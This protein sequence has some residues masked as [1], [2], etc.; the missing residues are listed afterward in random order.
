[1][2]YQSPVINH[3]HNKVNVSITVSLNNQRY[4]IPAKKT[5]VVDFDMASVAND[6]ERSE[7][8]SLVKN[9]YI[10]VDV[11]VL[12]D[13]KY[14]K[15]GSYTVAK[16][17]VA[18]AKPVTVATN[19]NT[20]TKR[21]ADLNIKVKDTKIADKAVTVVTEDTTDAVDPHTKESIKKPQQIKA[22]TNN[23]KEPVAKPI[24]PTKDGE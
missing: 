13:D 8:F 20:T 3:V 22:N 6:R 15:A 16:A 21:A 14:A 1:M 4:S 24:D 12:A 9:G 19:P 17:E 23:S 11:M 5:T 7:L 18:K 2:I 10:E